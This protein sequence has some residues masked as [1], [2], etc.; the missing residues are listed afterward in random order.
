MKIKLPFQNMSSNNWQNLGLAALCLFYLLQI[1]FDLFWKNTCGHL[2][3][4][5]CAFWSAG[6]IANTRGYAAVYDL[7]LMG[8]I[9]KTIFPNL[10][11]ITPTPFLPIFIVPFQP[12]ALLNVSISFWTWTALNIAVLFLYLRLLSRR[13]TGKAIS[14]RFAALIFLSLPVFIN[15]FTGQVNVW[16]VICI[17]EF[18]RATLTD[19]PFQ[20]GLWLG[21]LLLKPQILFLIV[22]ILIAQRSI[23]ILAGF[24]TSSTALVWVSIFL[25][26]VSG[27]Q[28]LA[29]LWLGY[30]GGLPTN[31]VAI[32]MNWR[33]IGLH[34]G[35][36]AF[37]MTGWIVVGLGL[38]TT[39][40]ATI[41]LWR[42]PLDFSSSNFVVAL[43]GLL[44]ATGLF[45]WHSHIHMA[46]ILIPPLIYLSAQKKMPD[47]IL[48]YWV[49]IPA[50]VYAA[51]FVTAS[52]VQVNILPSA[53]NGLLNFLRGA[54]GFGMNI[55]LLLWAM[56]K[57]AAND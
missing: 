4:D 24:A 18:M 50:G 8:E 47:Q 40:Y 38:T 41:Y 39:L 44:A 48:N 36:I 14:V 54:S 9:Q 28:K 25:A 27:L 49:F 55:F 37:P 13:I 35:G 6:Q 52:F 10:G 12:F 21:G 57:S 2:A 56:K 7:Q 34:L 15:F 16:L 11:A 19:K 20:A 51:V 5:Y 22:L 53:I 29:G 46:M 3:I 30:A 45:A 31:D 1:G 32:M 33:M 17:G 43:V 23:R 42:K 26:G